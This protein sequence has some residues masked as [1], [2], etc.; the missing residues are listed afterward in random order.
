M[1]TP[2]VITDLST[3]AA[4]NFPSGSDSPASLDDVQRAHGAFIA[5]LRDGA[6]VPSATAKTTPVDADLIPIND[7]AASNIIKK[8]TWANFKATLKTYFDTLYATAGTYV[9]AGAA[10]GSGLTQ[11]TGKLLGR[12]TASTGAIEEITPGSTL[13]F[14]AGALD[15]ARPYT[16]GTAVATTSGTSVNW[17]SIPSWVEVITL[18]LF[19][20]SLTQNVDHFLIQIG[21][22]GSPTTSG[23]LSS[24]VYISSGATNG[25]STAG[26]ILIS[27]AAGNATITWSGKITITRISSTEWEMSGQLGSDIGS[28]LLSSS[29]VTLAGQL[30]NLRLTTNGTSTVDAG[31]A[32]LSYQ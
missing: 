1:P 30:D 14:A 4:S 10:T 15:V 6:H 12:T 25:S 21:T 22:G 17:A 20:V 8:V 9:T 7:S 26:L 28:M 23:Y 18:D 27:G 2:T 19:G 5:Q 24:G 3:T 13:T 29:R 11:S 32:K 16:P 31:K